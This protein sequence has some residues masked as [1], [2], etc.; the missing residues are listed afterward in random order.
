MGGASRDFPLL[1]CVTIRAPSVRAHD[2][3]ACALPTTYAATRIWSEGEGVSVPYRFIQI[4]VRRP[5]R[6]DCRSMYGVLM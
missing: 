6:S 3:D 1:G 5:Y 4:L 2:E